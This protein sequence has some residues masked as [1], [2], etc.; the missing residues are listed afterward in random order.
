MRFPERLRAEGA[1]PATVDHAGFDA[2][3]RQH[4]DARGNVDYAGLQADRPALDAYLAALADADPGALSRDEQ[5]A[6]YINAYNAATLRLI[7]DNYPLASI[8]ELDGGKP[9]DVERV[10]LGGTTYSLNEIENDIIRPRFSEPRIHFAVNCAAASCP[11]LRDGAFTADALDAQL[12]EQTR[13]FLTS[14]T[15]TTVAG[16]VATVSK[17]FDWYG[18][19][20]D[21]VAG[22]IADY[23]DDVTASTAI[24]FR[25][26]DWSLNAQ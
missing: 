10:D 2:L 22:F 1:A 17:I 4:V 25:E 6:Y 8:T 11:P 7:V 13:A 5:L 12:D 16:G 19:D 24:A 9:W 14:P 26:Y 23:R 18:A 15:Y 3:L 21:S 20:F